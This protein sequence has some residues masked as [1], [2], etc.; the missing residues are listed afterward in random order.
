[1]QEALRSTGLASWI[2]N[3]PVRA[4]S[5]LEHAASRPRVLQRPD[6]TGAARPDGCVL[7]PDA[8]NCAGTCAG[9]RRTAAG[10][11]TSSIRHWWPSRRRLPHRRLSSGAASVTPISPWDADG[12]WLQQGLFRQRHWSRARSRPRR[13]V[14]A[15][16]RWLTVAFGRGLHESTSA[17]RRQPFGRGGYRPSTSAGDGRL[18][19]LSPQRPGV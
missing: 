14:I 16:G 5:S 7:P 17:G 2:G 3:R 18:P 19:G 11:R 13:A 4:R 8:C 15:F 9:R 12:E 10:S 6:A 1:V